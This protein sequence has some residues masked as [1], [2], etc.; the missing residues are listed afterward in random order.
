MG[1]WAVIYS[2]VTGNTKKVAEAIAAQ[3]EEA[4]VF[5]VQ[6]APT[7]LSAYEVVCI[8]Y[9]LKY[10]PQVHGA[11][12]CFF[13]TH[14]TDP[15]SEHAI[16]S[17]ARA[18]YALGDGCEILGTFGCRGAINEALKEKRKNAGPDDPHGGAKSL[19]RWAEAAG[20]PNAGD[21]QA[22]RDFAAAMQHK[23]VVRRQYRAKKAAKLAAL[24]QK[25]K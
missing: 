23:L 7:D 15:H 16:T 6:E 12:V 14:G 2:S 22:A 4:D 21:L 18:A 1:K 11:Q 24:K 17:F 13:Q 5:R 3:V 19:K 10:L 9:W 8:G 25:T 20:Q